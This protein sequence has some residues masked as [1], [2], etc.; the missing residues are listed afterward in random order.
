MN[1][2][3]HLLSQICNWTC[4]SGTGTIF[5]QD[6]TFRDVSVV[7]YFKM[8]HWWFI[9]HRDINYPDCYIVSEASTGCAIMEYCYDTVR[10]AVESALPIIKA[11]RY[12]FFTSTKEKLT[13][14]RYSLL[15]RN[16]NIQTLSI[17]SALWIL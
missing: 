16:L 10:D 17:D 1:L 11:K 8:Y 6:R 13:K 4:I 9:V 3:Q 15:N 2:P 5:M 14:Y 12:Y 7:G